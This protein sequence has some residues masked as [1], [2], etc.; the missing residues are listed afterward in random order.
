MD[1]TSLLDLPSLARDLGP[2]QNNVGR[3][4]QH[5]SSRER[6]FHVVWAN[7]VVR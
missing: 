4:V 5:V 6:V 2:Y 1:T 3:L 7:R